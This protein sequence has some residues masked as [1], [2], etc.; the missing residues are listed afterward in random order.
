MR[1]YRRIARKIT[2]VLFLS[3][4]LSS[5]GFIAAFTVNALVAVDL[6]GQTAMAGVPGALYVLGQA[7]GALVWG[8][9]MEW[10][11]RRRGLAF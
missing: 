5:A 8:L 10:I 9:S 11:G 3:Q 6:T 1:D 4:S 7:C 2:W